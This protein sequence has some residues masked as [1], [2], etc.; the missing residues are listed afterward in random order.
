MNAHAS[1]EEQRILTE[2]GETPSLL[3]EKKFLEERRRRLEASLHDHVNEI[4]DRG[5]HAGKVALAGAGA[6]VGV[7]LLT[8]AIGSLTGSRKHKKARALKAHVRMTALGPGAQAERTIPAEKAARRSR[9][10]APAQTREYYD[11]PAATRR[12][13]PASPPPAS[14]P[15]GPSLFQT[16][17]ESEAGR[18]MSNQLVALLMV[19]VTRKLESVLQIERSA[20][21]G[22]VKESDLTP[23]R[24]VDPISDAKVVTD[25]AEPARPN[26]SSPP[27]ATT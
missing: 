18:M 2:A 6:L 23:Y 17:M 24:I 15:A 19:F 21:I 27:A 4:K 14:E 5:Q 20:D 9:E 26:A 8:K 25:D 10:E 1:P 7:W 11:E 3:D 22:S 16:F 12:A 13:R